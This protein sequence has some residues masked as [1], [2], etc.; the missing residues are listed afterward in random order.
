MDCRQRLLIGVV[1][2]LLVLPAPSAAAPGGVDI[3]SW[4]VT[5]GGRTI[6]LRGAS[7]ELARLTLEGKTIALAPEVERPAGPVTFRLLEITKVDAEN[8]MLKQVERFTLRPGA[9]YSTAWQPRLTVVLEGVSRSE[10][11]AEIAPV[12]ETLVSWVVRLPTAENPEKEIKVVGKAGEMARIERPG[13]TL[14]F[15]PSVQD[16]RV[17]F[18]VYQILKEDG[19]ETLKEV[20]D[21]TL[22]DGGEVKSRNPAFFLKLTQVASTRSGH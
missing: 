3:A 15:E 20:G 11:A 9:S 12:P 17:N 16:S 18:K 6:S 21:Y 22:P 5:V 14:G 4:T 7:G 13:L 1:A 19:G 2:V 10:G 8:E